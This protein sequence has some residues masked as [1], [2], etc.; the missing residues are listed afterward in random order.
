M[1]A[2]QR[3]AKCGWNESNGARWCTKCGSATA[4]R[5]ARLKDGAAI[6][7]AIAGVIA[8][9][10]AVWTV[11]SVV[12]YAGGAMLVLAGLLIGAARTTDCRCVACGLVVNDAHLFPAERSA[13]LMRR[14]LLGFGGLALAAIPL[15][16]GF[17]MGPVSMEAAMPNG[18][19][20]VKLPWSYRDV[21]SE[22]LSVPTPDGRIEATVQSAS[23]DMLYQVWR[24]EMPAGSAA[25]KYESLLELLR[26]SFAALG[27]QLTAKMEC[28]ADM[29]CVEF[30]FKGSWKGADRVGRGRA[31]G[32]DRSAVI[33]LYA[34]PTVE[35]LADGD[36]LRYLDSF[37]KKR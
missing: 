35:S 37:A 31:F 14:R 25:L 10:V 12:A 34:G 36:S 16:A 26:L 1:N 9:A 29:T 13:R 33:V 4:L 11:H 21:K 24:V 20:T 28:G 2:G 3:C 19:W 30:D 32:A 5:D 15:L 7:L 23:A 27:G 22:A 8:G 6:G 17:A 18:T